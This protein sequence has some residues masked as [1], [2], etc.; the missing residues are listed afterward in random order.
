ME[1]N[2]IQNKLQ[3]ELKK[4]DFYERFHNMYRKKA[5]KRNSVYEQINKN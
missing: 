3:I 4:K 5:E 1:I 2:M